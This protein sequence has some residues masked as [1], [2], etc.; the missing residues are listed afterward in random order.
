MFNEEYEESTFEKFLD[1]YGAYIAVGGFIFVVHMFFFIMCSSAQ[2]SYTFEKHSAMAYQD[3]KYHPANPSR[4]VNMLNEVSEDGVKRFVWSDHNGDYKKCRKDF[5]RLIEMSNPAPSHETMPQ[6]IELHEFGDT[7]V[8][9]S[10]QYKD[11]ANWDRLAD[12]FAQQFTDCKYKE[13]IVCSSLYGKNAYTIWRDYKKR[14]WND[15]EARASIYSYA[16]GIQ[17]SVKKN[18]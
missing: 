8:M 3:V 2:R 5:A 15:E 6:I 13:V 1:K 7:L 10:G 16:R 17:E 12:D 9:E 14:D 11:E 18:H 4:A